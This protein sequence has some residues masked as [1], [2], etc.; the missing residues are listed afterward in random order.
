MKVAAAYFREKADQCR[1]L[2]HALRDQT[3]PVVPALLSMAEEFEVSAN[4]LE[5]RIAR[6]AAHLSRGEDEPPL[7]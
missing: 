4:A 1:Q 6:D 3:D 5:T 2:A 7:H